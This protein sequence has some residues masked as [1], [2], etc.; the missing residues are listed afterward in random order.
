LLRV[1]SMRDVD[2][3]KVR[4]THFSR[5]PE[6]CGRPGDEIDVPVG[7]ARMWAGS[8]GAVIVGEA[9]AIIAEPAAET[10]ESRRQTI[11]GSGG[12]PLRS[13][14]RRSQRAAQPTEEARNEAS[15]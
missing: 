7:L 5:I 10:T 6:Y 9:S 3:V 15:E 8:R 14:S 11:S 13:G 12:G 4:L 2:Y 1:R